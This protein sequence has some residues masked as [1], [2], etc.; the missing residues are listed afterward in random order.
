MTVIPKKRLGQHFLAD[1]NILDVIGRLAE[2]APGGRRAR[3]RPRARRP[4]PLPR[5]AC[6]PRPR[7][8]ARPLARAAPPGAGASFRTSTLHWGDALALDLASLDPAPTKLVANLPYNIATPV[9]A[10]SL[11]GLPGDRAL[12]R[13]GA[14][15]GRRPLLRRAVDE[16]LRR[17]LGARA[18]RRP[19]HRLPPGRPHGLPAAAERRLGARRLPARA[20]ARALRAGQGRR[21]G[22]VRAPAQDARPIRSRSP[23]S[24]TASSAAAALESIGRLAE[25]RAEA[26]EPTEFVA[27]DAEEL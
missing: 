7:R 23:G 12:V 15:G 6:A 4:D 5:R 11:T 22:L 2:L 25:T 13:D 26:L 18:A 16:G 9:V 8:R 19:P 24:P 20:A 21:R 17:R 3:D 10:E 1:G 14:A 27:L